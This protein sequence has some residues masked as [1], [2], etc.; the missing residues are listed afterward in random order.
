MTTTARPTRGPTQP[1]LPPFP[2]ARFTLDQY[3]AIIRSGLLDEDEPVELLRGW[4]TP[5]MPRNPPHDSTV[6][7]L[8]RLFDS[9]LGAPWVVRPQC[10]VSIGE[11]EPEPDVA[12]AVGP[13]GR[14]DGHHP[15]A[16]EIR[17]LVEVA[18]TSLDRD[19][20]IKGPVYAEAGIPVYW[21]V[22]L[23]E[24]Q[25]EVYTDP[26]GPDERPAYRARRDYRL[27]EAIPVTLPE[28][29]VEPMPVNEILPT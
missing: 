16:G 17:L 20:D 3:H 8:Q 4:I 22:N 28:A 21:V 1:P 19:R 24:R 13:D 23:P 29:A 12:I 26:T 11:S 2:V 25:V 9:R 18:D 27:G 10:A 15:G 14:Y 7:R 5:K 6:T